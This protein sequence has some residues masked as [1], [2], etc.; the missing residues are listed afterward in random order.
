[1]KLKYHISKEENTQY[2]T[3]LVDGKVA[4]KAKRRQSLTDYLIRSKLAKNSS[5]A[6]AILKRARGSP[7]PTL[8]ATPSNLQ[9]MLVG[10]FE[11]FK[12]EIKG[13]IRSLTEQIEAQKITFD[14]D[15]EEDEVS[16][17]DEEDEEPLGDGD[18]T[19]EDN[20]E[21]V[22][23]PLTFILSH[24]GEYQTVY[25]DYQTNLLYLDRELER[26]VG[27]T[28]VWEDHSAEVSGM[29][30]NSSNVV[31]NPVRLKYDK[32]E[33][34]LVL[35]KLTDATETNFKD[36]PPKTTFCEFTADKMGSLIA[37]S[38]V[39]KQNIFSFHKSIQ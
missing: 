37:T 36:L 3:L 16:D 23:E 34:A 9:Q 6:L 39:A 31:L 7:P 21:C 11:D 12:A 10:L 29:F 30:V 1:M 13:D 15:T 28:E 4:S 20:E 22:S 18:N 27:H 8:P 17:E 2:H 5:Q 33:E 32:I 14:G 24:E 19:D 38:E 35:F 25:L 26:Q